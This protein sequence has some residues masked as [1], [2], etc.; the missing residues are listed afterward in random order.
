MKKITTL[1]IAV[2]F[3]GD[4]F[5]QDIETEDIRKGY[6]G[7]S[8]GPAF[9]IGDIKND[10]ISGGMHLNLVNF[11]YLFSEHIGI[12]A[13]WFGSSFVSKENSKNAIGLGGIMVGPLFSKSISN[14]QLEIDFKPLI[15]FANG[16][17]I[18]GN[19]TSSS[20]RTLA[21]GSG[22]TARWNCWSKFSLSFGFDCYSAK[23]EDVDLSSCAVVFGVNYRLK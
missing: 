9:P 22:I 13:T 20:S 16:T 2:L 5:S 23:P 11:G 21:L 14:N 6:I 12:S 10:M 19:K 17:L 15:G 7:I 1:I 8:M 3:I 4:L 18:E